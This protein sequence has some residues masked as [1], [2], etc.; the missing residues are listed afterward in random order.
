MRGEIRLILDREPNVLYSE[1]EIAERLVELGKEISKDYEGK[2]II[3]ISL[4]KGG[5][6]FT[7][8]LIR[9]IS[10]PVN[11]DFMIT[12]SYGHSETSTGIVN[13][14]QDIRED[15]EGKDVIIMDDIID[16][17]NTMFKVKKYIESKNPASVKIATMLD[18]PSRREADIDPDYVGFEIPNLFILGYGLDYEDFCRGI[19]YIATF[20]EV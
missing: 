7:A 1:E 3:A 9:R 19:P 17:G 13:I 5:F 16:S 11:V 14:I 2:E 6:V 18:K 10:V 4:L 15:I 8:D 12:S 20:D